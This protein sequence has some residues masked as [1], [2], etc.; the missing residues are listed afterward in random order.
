MPF[1]TNCGAK[2]NDRDRFCGECGFPVKKLSQA[3]SERQII[4]FEHE[5]DLL[6]HSRDRD[7]ILVTI[8]NNKIQKNGKFEGKAI[9]NLVNHQKKGIR[10]LLEIV[11]E[12]RWIEWNEGGSDAFLERDNRFE[13]IYEYREILDGEKEY[14]AGSHIYNFCI[15]IP[16]N[17]ENWRFKRESFFMKKL[18]F[19]SH[20]YLDQSTHDPRNL[21]WYLVVRF[22][23][24]QLGISTYKIVPLVFTN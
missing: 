20:Q 7:E 24:R 21:T 9:L 2:L 6:A 3:P 23:K 8:N 11:G 22:D 10:V 19:K 4:G 12:N 5:A 16:S 18:G 14:I 17:I 1:C 13:R 15:Q